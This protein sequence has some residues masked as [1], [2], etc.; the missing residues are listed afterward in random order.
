[1]H[2]PE[3]DALAAQLDDLVALVQTLSEA[4]F[5]R[6]SRCPGWSVA[7]LVAHCEGI[8]RRLAGENAEP[9]A[10]D[11]EIDRLGYYRYDPDG[12]R[13]GEASGRTFSEVVRDRVIAEVGGRTAA[14][15]RAGLE[16]AVW[17]AVDGIAQVPA[18]RVIH[19]SGHPRIAFGEFVASRN[20]E[21]GVHTMDI[22]HALGRAEQPNPAAAP[23]ITAVL[24]GLLED[25]LP[26]SLDWDTTTYILT[27]TGRREL[28]PHERDTL[29]VLASRFPLLR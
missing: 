15:L 13:D 25:R 17:A 9:V 5:A 24:D 10:G 11:A 7:E 14:Q 21:F 26:D 18:D 1:M 23:I 29:G 22:A 12:R 19:R 6:P 8:L 20:V 2:G 16:A 28:S 4:D 27:G 3:V